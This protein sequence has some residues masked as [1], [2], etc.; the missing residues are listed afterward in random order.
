MTTVV[1]NCS[2]RKRLPPAPTLC[3]STL[4]KGPLSSVLTEWEARVA[5]ADATISAGHL[6]GARAFR[7]ATIAAKSSDADLWIISAGLGLVR[8]TDSVPAYD[9]TVSPGSSNNVLDIVEGDVKAHD[10]WRYLTAK[11]E[12]F[13]GLSERLM[14]LR[15]PSDL[16]LLA[17][18]VPYLQ[19][20][21]T[22]LT[23]LP[24]ARHAAIRIFTAPSFRFGDASLDAAF[25][26]Y[27]ARLDGPS[28]PYRGTST[29][30]AARALRDFTTAILPELP[31]AS[32]KEHAVAVAKRLENWPRAVR[33]DRKRKSDSELLE[34]I[35]ANWS[36]GGSSAS[37]M[38]R[39]IRDELGVACKQARL[40]ALC[41]V[42]G[43]EMENSR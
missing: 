15:D 18:P 12:R 27:D 7:E 23:G 39:L 31:E 10:W 41:G 22:D 16:V 9:L 20:I 4:P 42:V 13:L 3:S 6:Y 35:R 28:S 11:T 5:A 2:K 38:L 1:V 24:P 43:H 21:R 14:Q 26:P 36:D 40:K 19:M 25:M 33:L 37:R 30:F 8:S 34:I 17:L 29:D 32:S